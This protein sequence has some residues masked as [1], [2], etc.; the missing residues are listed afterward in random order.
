MSEDIVQQT[1]LKALMHAD[2]FRMESTLK[3]WLASIAMNEVRQVYRCKWRTRSAPLISENVESDLS[4][5]VE[6]PGACYQARQRE[7]LVRQAV[8]RL[9]DPYRCVVELCDL[10]CLSLK[11]AAARL[12]LTM[13]AI[14]TRRR[15]AQRKLSPLVAG[16]RS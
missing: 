10:E 11:E 8:S 2:Q 5:L 14:K 13:P 4:P 6:S 9:P 7:M 15:R 1:M 12:H 3:T 16:L